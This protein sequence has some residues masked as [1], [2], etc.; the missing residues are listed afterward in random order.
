MSHP[1]CSWRR[2]VVPY[3]VALVTGY[4][5]WPAAHT[6]D[7]PRFLGPNGDGT[8]KET[9]LADAWPTN[10]PP[11][12]WSKAVG[13]GYSAPS[14]LGQRL[15]LHHRQSD[16][17]IVECFDAASGKSIWRQATPSAFIDPYGY[18]NGPRATPLLTTNRCFTFGAEGGLRC[19]DLETGREI[20][21]RV[22]SAARG[23]ASRRI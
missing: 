17:E 10:G 20:W 11:Q 7:W 13:T 4:L 1:A 15:V 14:I 3:R 19:L 8:S 9:G 5:I 6:D 22:R 23:R 21:S 2:L 16:Q 18:N 12:L